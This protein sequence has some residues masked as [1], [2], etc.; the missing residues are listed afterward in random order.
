M[1]LNLLRLLGASRAKM[2]FYFE[3]RSFLGYKRAT[4]FS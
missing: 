2:S 4:F 1:H 3:L